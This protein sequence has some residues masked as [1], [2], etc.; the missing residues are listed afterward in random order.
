MK[1]LECY[2]VTA[3]EQVFLSSLHQLLARRSA[4]LRRTGMLTSMDCGCRIAY[5]H[6]RFEAGVEGHFSRISRRLFAEAARF[7]SPAVSE[8]PTCG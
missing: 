8:L 7:R 1:R 5:P 2:A 3:V 4:N 6:R